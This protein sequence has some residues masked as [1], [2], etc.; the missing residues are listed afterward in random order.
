MGDQLKCR[1]SGTDLSA[2]RK[3][4]ARHGRRGEF[5]K[6][7]ACL[8]AALRFLQKTSRIPTFDHLTVWNELGMVYK[9]LGKF[10][11]AE[12]YYRLALRCA[13]QCIEHPQRTS[14][15]ASIYHNLGGLDHARRRFRR[16][17]IY[18]RRALQLRREVESPSSG[19]VASDMVAL[20]AIL[21]G[22]RKFAESEK[23][24]NSALRIYRRAYGENHAETAVLLNNLAALYQ[25]TKRPHRAEAFYL[26]AL[27]MK[28]RILPCSHPDIAVTMNNLAMLY[29]SQGNRDG[30]LR[31]FED[32]AGILAV[33][34]GNHH[35][36]TK[37]VRGN[38]RRLR[39]SRPRSLT[40]F[41]PIQ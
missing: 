33:S 18:A 2:L 5:A 1:R 21:D 16:G 7:E 17:E 22:L 19:A 38:L 15:L 4:A 31:W 24:Y 3:T 25:A 34:L 35:P 40:L 29:R 39:S 6:S 11:Q 10:G 32:A 26:A 12:K 8:R 36:S 30:A 23:L 28:R 13:R 14:F 9:Y 41:P 27:R 20:A 37:L